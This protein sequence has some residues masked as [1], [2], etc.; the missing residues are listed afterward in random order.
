MFSKIRKFRWEF[1]KKYCIKTKNYVNHKSHKSLIV[2]KLVKLVH[3]VKNQRFL[4]FC[5][6]KLLCF[7]NWA[8]A[9]T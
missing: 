3:K 6:L 2:P 5:F 7:F 4:K 1:V 9:M 8:N